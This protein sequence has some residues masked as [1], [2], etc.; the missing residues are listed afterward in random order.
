MPWILNLNIGT[1]NEYI[2][3]LAYY[4][5]IQGH[6]YIKVFAQ[7]PNR[8]KIWL[9]RLTPPRN[10]HCIFQWHIGNQSVIKNQSS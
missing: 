10:P 2:K 9:S 1:I 8:L 6:M 3:E 7:Q 4:I 5:D